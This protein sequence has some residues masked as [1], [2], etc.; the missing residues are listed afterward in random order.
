MDPA[1][2]SAE[3]MAGEQLLVTG[4]CTCFGNTKQSAGNMARPWSPRQGYRRHHQRPHG[5]GHPR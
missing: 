1:S 5:Q 2:R 3:R 4:E